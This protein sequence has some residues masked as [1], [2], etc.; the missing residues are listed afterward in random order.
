V[1]KSDKISKKILGALVGIVTTLATVIAGL[2]LEGREFMEL[3]IE[4]YEG[5]LETVESNGRECEAD[6]RILRRDLTFQAGELHELREQIAETRG[7]IEGRKA[8]KDKGLSA[9]K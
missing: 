7:F 4:R 3:S 8:L 1:G 5:R 9:T 2:H 6:R